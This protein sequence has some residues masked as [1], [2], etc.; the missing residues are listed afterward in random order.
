MF[1]RNTRRRSAR[2]RGRNL[3][4]FLVKRVG[5]KK[6]KAAVQASMGEMPP[7]G[8]CSVVNK[9]GELTE[10]AKEFRR[11]RGCDGVPALVPLTNVPCSCSAGPGRVNCQLCDGSGWQPVELCPY[12]YSLPEWSPVLGDLFLAWEKGILPVG[13][14]LMS[15][16]AVFRDALLTYGQE[17][18]RLIRQK[19]KSEMDKTRNG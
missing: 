5:L 11:R 4:R 13:G 18:S 14:C 19:E 6:L 12:R 8:A 2:S 15:Q 9:D 1:V 17:T 7:C 10:A 16:S 3:E